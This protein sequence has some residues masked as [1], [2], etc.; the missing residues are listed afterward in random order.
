MVAAKTRGET[1]S[2]ATSMLSPK[3]P[4]SYLSSR[5]VDDNGNRV[6]EVLA[7]GLRVVPNGDNILGRW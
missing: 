3:S 2:R 6:S 7:L 5:R 4:E 1:A